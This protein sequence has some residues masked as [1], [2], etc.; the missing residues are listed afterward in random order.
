M[1]SVHFGEAGSGERRR[2]WLSGPRERKAGRSPKLGEAETIEMDSLS[3]T[4]DSAFSPEGLGRP[5]G[6]LTESWTKV[7]GWRRALVCGGGECSKIRVL[8]ASGEFPV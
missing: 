2:G 5:V 6:R 8:G 3:K 7:A 4:L 1:R